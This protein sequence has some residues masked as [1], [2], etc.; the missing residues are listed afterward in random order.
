MDYDE[1]A[2]EHFKPPKEVD[3]NSSGTAEATG[4]AASQAK[5]TTK[6]QLRKQ[7][8]S[9]TSEAVARAGGHVQVEESSTS[10]TSCDGNNLIHDLLPEGLN[11][12]WDYD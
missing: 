7:C 2:K 8:V 4:A 11:T 9:T 6:K 1:D 10:S 12:K 3:D 5:G